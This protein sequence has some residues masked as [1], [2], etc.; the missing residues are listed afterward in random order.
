MASRG[1]YITFNEG[2]KA[3]THRYTVECYIHDFGVGSGARHHEDEELSLDRRQ[4]VVVLCLLESRLMH[5]GA[6]HRV[7]RRL[8]L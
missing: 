7:S 1:C 2:T 5:A 3:L 4:V 8:G 6:P